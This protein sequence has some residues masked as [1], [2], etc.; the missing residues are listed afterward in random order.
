[1][2]THFCHKIFGANTL[3][4]NQV[5]VCGK[6]LGADKEEAQ[7]DLRALNGSVSHLTL[8]HGFRN[9]ILS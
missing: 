9:G 5:R 7:A 2:L 3:P 1:M 6:E 8:K 4:V